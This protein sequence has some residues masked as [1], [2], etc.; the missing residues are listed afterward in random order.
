MEMAKCFVLKMSMEAGEEEF[1]LGAA[2][3][4]YWVRRGYGGFYEGANRN[5]DRGL[6][7]QFSICE[8][9]KITSRLGAEREKD[10]RWLGR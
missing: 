2:G 5:V 6:I 4:N 9:M 10:S 8:I 1:F 7:S 3:C